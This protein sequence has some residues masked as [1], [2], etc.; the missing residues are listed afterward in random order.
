MASTPPSPS[1][2]ARVPVLRAVCTT[3]GISV[4]RL[5]VLGVGG[6]GAGAPQVL[7][8]AGGTNRISSSHRYCA[9]WG[10]GTQRRPLKVHYRIFL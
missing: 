5:P 8:L 1:H 9:L 3:L 10:R 6:E 4:S 2:K 7:E